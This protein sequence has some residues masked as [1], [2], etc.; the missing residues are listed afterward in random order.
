MRGT[1]SYMRRTWGVNKENVNDQKFFPPYVQDL[2]RSFFLLN[3]P[4]TLTIVP[5]TNTLGRTSKSKA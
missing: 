4:K 5:G 3:Y 1:L 2:I